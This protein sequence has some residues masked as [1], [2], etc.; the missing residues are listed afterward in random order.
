MCDPGTIYTDELFQPV[1]KNL[2]PVDNYGRWSYPE[3]I[4]DYD[5]EGWEKI[6]WARAENIFNSKNY[7]VFYQGIADDDIIQGVLG[8]YYFLSTVVA[9]YKFPK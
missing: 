3:G 4:E 7:Q 8:D 2:C 9:L 6:S 1:K 5:V